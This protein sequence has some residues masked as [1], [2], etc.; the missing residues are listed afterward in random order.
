M[1]VSSAVRVPA[2]S[3]Y[4]T[5]YPLTVA[6]DIPL[7]FT[8]L[9]SGNEQVQPEGV[10]AIEGGARVRILRKSVVEAAVFHNSYRRLHSYQTPFPLNPSALARLLRPGGTNPATPPTIPALLANS[11]EGAS[12]GGEASIHYDV[13]RSWRLV[14]I[15]SGAFQNIHVRPGFDPAALLDMPR[16]YPNHM[17]QVRSS[18]ELG[19]RWML[20]T[21]FY[22]VGALR[23]A[24]GVRLPAFTRADFRLE[25][26]LGESSGIYLNG[27]NVLRPRQ[28]EFFGSAPFP[29]G[30]IGRS[31]AVGFRW[32]R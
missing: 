10:R 22:R 15:Y 32:E 2:H 16:Y 20:D 31:I 13:S 28:Q 25:R 17:A 11:Q 9:L 26:K 5:R 3:D 19:R 4:A 1:A 14:A 24:G 29:A 27:Q 21:E 6:R 8:L 7:P 12:R 23:D 18:W 30:A